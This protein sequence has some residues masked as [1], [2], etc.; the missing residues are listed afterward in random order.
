[1][2]TAFW[3]MTLSFVLMAYAQQRDHTHLIDMRTQLSATQDSLRVAQIRLLGHDPD[4]EFLTIHKTKC[5]EG[6]KVVYQQFDT[7][8]SR[9]DDTTTWL[10]WQSDSSWGEPDTLRRSK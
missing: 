6:T 5:L 8:W 10:P 7:T 9:Y 1:M 2:K 4:Q 3:F